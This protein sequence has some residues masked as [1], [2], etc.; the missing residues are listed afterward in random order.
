M[1]S[2]VEMQAVDGLGALAALLT[3]ACWLPQALKILRER[4]ARALSWLGTGT[5]AAGIGCW[6]AYGLALRDWPLI[7]SDAVTL[8]LVLAILALKLRHG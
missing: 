3:T 5:F 7:V 1:G 4:D 2:A 6:L 8:A